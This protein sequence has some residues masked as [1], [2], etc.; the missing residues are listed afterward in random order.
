MAARFDPVQK[1]AVREIAVDRLL[2]ET[3]SPYMRVR[4]K[5]HNT[6]V[7]VGEVANVVDRIGRVILGEVLRTTA[8]KSRRLYNL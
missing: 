2:V 1:S 3:D 6:P 4:G 5:L 8:E 7:Y